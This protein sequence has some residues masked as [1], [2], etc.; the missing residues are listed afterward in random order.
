MSWSRAKCAGGLADLLTGATVGTGQLVA[1]FASPPGT[2]NAP[3]LV[4]SRPVEV[5]YGLGGFAVDS[6]E[7]P[8]VCVGPVDG[9]DLVDELANVVRSAVLDDPTLGGTV[10]VAYAEVLRNYREQKVA[11]ADVLTADLVLSIQQ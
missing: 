2:L 11:G 8:V 5:R 3:A 4:V 7:L 1:V 10:Q 9:D 6:V